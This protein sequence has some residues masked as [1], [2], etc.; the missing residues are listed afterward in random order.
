MLTTIIIGLLIASAIGGIII[1][2]LAKHFG[3]ISNA[4]F[5]NSFLICLISSIINYAIWHL[6]GSDS[7]RM[8]FEGI[9]VM[10][11][12]ILSAI[13]I[14]VGKFIWKCNWFQSIKANLIWIIAYAIFMEYTF[15][16][17]T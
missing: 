2:I 1:W 9:I 13:Y 4:T 6:I 12:V 17:L 11:L 14:T 10:N 3:K 7:F 8:G 15:S 16:K 5:A